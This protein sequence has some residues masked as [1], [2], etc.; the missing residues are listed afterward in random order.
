M[1]GRRSG[2]AADHISS[3]LELGAVWAIR[4]AAVFPSIS[5]LALGRVHAVPVLWCG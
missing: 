1:R 2:E 3:A 4:V 5:L